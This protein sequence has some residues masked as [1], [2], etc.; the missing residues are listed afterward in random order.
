MRIIE[1]IKYNPVEACKFFA[2]VLALIACIVL[3]FFL[4]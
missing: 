1:E 2:L 4:K 3:P